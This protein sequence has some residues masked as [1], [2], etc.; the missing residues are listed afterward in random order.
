MMIPHGPR[1]CRTREQLRSELDHHNRGREIEYGLKTSCQLSH[2]IANA[3]GWWDADRNAGELIALMHSELSK[4]LEAMRKDPN[5]PSEHC[6]EL[7]AVAEEAADVFISLSDFCQAAKI[8]LGLAVVRKM[9]FNLT[10]PHKHG[11]QF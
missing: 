7:S 11:K 5:K 1:E 6:P 3:G 4:M 10:R 2:A 8:D 9:Q